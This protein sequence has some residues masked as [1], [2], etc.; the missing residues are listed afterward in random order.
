MVGELEQG[1]LWREGPAM[2]DI[3]RK[4]LSHG[5]RFQT[6]DRVL[7]VSERLVIAQA[8]GSSPQTQANAS[9]GALW[10][11]DPALLDGLAQTVWIWAR[12][13]QGSTVLPLGLKAARRYDGNPMNGP[14][15]VC[16][17]VISDPQDP[18]SVSD[19]KVYDAD[20]QLCYRL[21]EFR[22]QSSPQLNRLGGG[23]QGGELSAQ[24]QPASVR[25]LDLA[26]SLDPTK[27]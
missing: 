4:W 8:H 15:T 23:W 6:L 11:F 12:K 25:P 18:S 9:P 13:V 1:M 27:G 7:S 3:Y 16:C 22:G 26:K 19:I 14:L 5:P 21:E 17:D 20:G 2:A 10:D 24:D